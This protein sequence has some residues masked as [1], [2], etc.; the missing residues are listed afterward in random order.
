MLSVNFG[1]R[2]DPQMTYRLPPAREVA[3]TAATVLRVAKLP[4]RAFAHVSVEPN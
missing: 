4:A 1:D 2:I 3:A